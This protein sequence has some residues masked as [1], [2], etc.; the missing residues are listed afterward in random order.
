[1][2]RSHPVYLKIRRWV[3][4]RL[5]DPA[6]HV[7][8][9]PLLV[10]RAHLPVLIAVAAFAPLIALHLLIGPLP[11]PAWLIGCVW[12]VASAAFMGWR[13][14]RLIRASSI[15]SARDYDRRAKFDLPP[16]YAASESLLAHQRRERRAQP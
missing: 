11:A 2:A 6:V 3:D 13:G 16:E 10:R 9:G 1:M 14:W 8:L 5:S 12:A 7:Q 15:K 4:V